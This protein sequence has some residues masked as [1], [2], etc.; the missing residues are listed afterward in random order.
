MLV[1]G[2]LHLE[3]GVP[4]R[5]VH[6]IWGPPSRINTACGDRSRGTEHSTEKA[7]Q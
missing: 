5:L 7:T 2:E 4:Y 1:P 3:V 6:G